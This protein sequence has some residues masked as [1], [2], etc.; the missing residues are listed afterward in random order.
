MATA[1]YI[2]GLSNR[3][4]CISQEVLN[5]SGSCGCCRARISIHLQDSAAVECI[6][7]AVNSHSTG[8]HDT[9]R[10]IKVIFISLGRILHPSSRHNT[11]AAVEVICIITNLLKSLVHS[12][13][14]WVK[15]T[16]L[17]FAVCCPASCHK[18]L[19]GKIPGNFLG[20]CKKCTLSRNTIATVEIILLLTDSCPS[21]CHISCTWIKVTC[22][23]LA[24]CKPACCH[25]PLDSVGIIEVALTL[26]VLGPT[27]SLHACGSIE[28]ILLA[29]QCK[30]S[31]DFLTILVIVRLSAFCLKSI[32]GCGLYICC[33]CVYSRSSCKKHQ[34]QKKSPNF[35]FSA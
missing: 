12:S 24:V 11:A 31:L 19:A 28:V 30:P 1:P 8:C 17:R 23:L 16:F 26:A 7:L 27:F 33:S 13:C 5:R 3:F 25:I 29:V 35:P 15:V 6:F 4:Q 34:D 2:K 10:W 32:L 22:I 20:I 14:T 21:G 18:A 9:S